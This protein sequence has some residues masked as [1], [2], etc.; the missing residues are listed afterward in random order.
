MLPLFLLLIRP[1][2]TSSIRSGEERMNDSGPSLKW[3]SFNKALCAYNMMSNYNHSGSGKRT[4]LSEAVLDGAHT[5][6]LA[7]AYQVQ[8]PH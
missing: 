1:K 2:P 7:K 8:T 3:A 6:S 4:T 5:H